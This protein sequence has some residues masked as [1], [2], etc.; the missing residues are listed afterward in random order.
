MKVLLALLGGALVG[1][2]AMRIRRSTGSEPAVASGPTEV[3]P[4]RVSV[5]VSAFA[6]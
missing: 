6:G 4:G 5:D 3:G 1:V 2:A